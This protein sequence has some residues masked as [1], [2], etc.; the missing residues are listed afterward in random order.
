MDQSYDA[1]DIVYYAGSDNAIIPSRSMRKN[2]REFDA[3][4]YTERTLVE[5]MVNTLTHFRRISPKEDTLVHAFFLS[6]ILL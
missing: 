5:R 4:L 2:S 3:D 6:F 1:D